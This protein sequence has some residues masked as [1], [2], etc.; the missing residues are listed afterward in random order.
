M[1][2]APTG[3]PQVVRRGRAQRDLIKKVSMDFAT[4]A[5]DAIGSGAAAAG[6]AGLSALAA[7]RAYRNRNINYR[8]RKVEKQTRLNRGE[9]K[10][11]D[12]V[13]SVAIANNS[14]VVVEL[15]A[16]SQ[17]DGANQRDG[18]HIRV[19]GLDIRSKQDASN[20][21]VYLVISPT[22][23]V[24]VYA[25]FDAVQGGHIIPSRKDDLREIKYIHEYRSVTTHNAYNRKF[26]KK[27]IHVR[28]NAAGSANGVQN[29]LF[30]VF[31]NNT[32]AGTTVHY[33]ALLYYRD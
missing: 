11:V 17:G 8:L 14:V 25:D 18:N 7:Y 2:L 9:L 3:P 24:P 20:I 33:S 23:Q 26:N 10:R 12:W 29:R 21:D 31:K 4:Y 30:L 6:T 5:G 32:G 13:N 15:T 27:P 22:G 16:I 19:R 28:Y 1:R